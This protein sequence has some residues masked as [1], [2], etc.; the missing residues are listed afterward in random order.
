MK[1]KIQTFDLKDA[2]R[3][4]Q[5]SNGRL[6]WVIFVKKDGT[7]R[8]ML[9]RLGVK[10][11]L[12]GGSLAYD[13]DKYGLLVVFDMQKCAYRMINLNTIKYAQVNREQ[14]LFL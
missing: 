5:N 10:K 12:R 1:N 7:T 9:A 6:F 11:Y 4:L 2:K 8:R 14:I 13:P 3:K